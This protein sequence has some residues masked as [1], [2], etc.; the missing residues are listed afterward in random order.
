[1]M[2]K[3]ERRTR[4]RDFAEGD[5]GEHDDFSRWQMLD[6]LVPF[7]DGHAV[8]H[9]SYGGCDEHALCGPIV[10]CCQHALD[11]YLEIYTQT[12]LDSATCEYM[13]ADQIV[14]WMDAGIQ[15]IYFIYCAPE[16]PKG[17]AASG[18]SGKQA[19]ETLYKQAPFRDQ[20]VKSGQILDQIARGEDQELCEIGADTL[21]IISLRESSQ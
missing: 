6:W 4:R 2:T 15:A 10:Y 12:R 14:T 9:H 19:R 11:R 20:F 8:I 16:V 1:M 13:P 21:P 17:L 18:M 5:G 3:N 7:S